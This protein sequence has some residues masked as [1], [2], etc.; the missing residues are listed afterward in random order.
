VG[1]QAPTRA[2]VDL[3]YP[4]RE[5]CGFVEFETAKLDLRIEQDLA[6]GEIPVNVDL[7]QIEQV[8]LNLVRNA[9]DALEEQPEAERRLAIFTRVK[10]DH[11]VL[12]V[13]DNGPGIPPERMEHL[14]DA[15]YTTKES[16]MGM[17]LAIS[18]TII[19]DHGGEIRAE[20]EPGKGTLFQVRLPLADAAANEAD[21]TETEQ[22]PAA[23]GMS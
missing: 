13:A 12:G 20:S 2:V 11:A 1:K 5:V 18:Q 23:A 4:V 16:G 17:G 19:D 7:V 8:L 6:E 10:G 14:F 15:F 3:N 22:P 9:L 21:T